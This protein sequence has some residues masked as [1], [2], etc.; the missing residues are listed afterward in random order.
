MEKKPHFMI[1]TT[2]AQ[3]P[4]N[5]IRCKQRMLQQ[6]RSSVP[7]MVPKKNS[8]MFYSARHKTV[9]GTMADNPTS[10]STI[11]TYIDLYKE[12]KDQ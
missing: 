1:V 9:Q 10:S 2:K 5:Q 7:R 4:M 8:V 12:K 11:L 3:K 6:W